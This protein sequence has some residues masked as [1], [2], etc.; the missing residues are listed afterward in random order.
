MN[1]LARKITFLFGTSVILSW[2]STTYSVL[3]IT[4][5]D[6]VN[7]PFHANISLQFVNDFACWFIFQ[8]RSSLQHDH[9][10][11]Q[12]TG[13]WP[14]LFPIS[15]RGPK[16]T[17]FLPQM[18]SPNIYRTQ[19][20]RWVSCALYNIVPFS[21]DI[22]AV[23]TERMNS[24]L[25]SRFSV[26][27]QR[28]PAEGWIRAF[29]QTLLSLFQFTEN[30]KCRR[31]S[32]ELISWGLDSSLERGRLLHSRA[33]TAKKCSQKCD[34]R[35]NLLFCKSNAVVVAKALL[36][37]LH[38]PAYGLLP[39]LKHPGPGVYSSCTYDDRVP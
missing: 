25:H 37:K 9:R 10:R 39:T 30:V 4:S 19:D 24:L 15:A 31:I 17:R 21:R 34:A 26:V 28:S 5:G 22:R 20:L 2:V 33:V 27:T 16:F 38:A 6:H 13:Y 32:L 1:D 3:Q 7:T 18:K 11:P 12:T 36:W 14:V 8:I 35:A 29:F 23:F